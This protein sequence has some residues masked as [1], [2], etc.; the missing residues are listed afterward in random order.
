MADVTP[1]ALVQGILL[2]DT[3]PGAP[4]LYQAP[5]ATTAIIRSMTFCNTDSEERTITVYLVASGGSEGDA[6]TILKAVPIKA[7]E[8]LEDGGPDA[9]RVLETGDFISAIADA[10][11]TVSM[12]VDGSEVA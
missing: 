11:D 2:D 7:G 3:A 5:A 1:K 8:T 10:A 9:L 4:G 6:N 12:R